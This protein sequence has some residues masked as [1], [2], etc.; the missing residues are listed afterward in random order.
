MQRSLKP[1]STGQ[2]R[3]DSPISWKLNRTSAPGLFRKQIVPLRGMGSMP[4]D[5]RHFDSGLAEQLMHSPCKRDQTGA[6]PVAG[7][8]SDGG[9]DVTASIRSCEDRRAGAAPVGLPIFQNARDAEIVEAAACKPALTRCESGRAL[10]F[11]G[12]R[13][14]ARRRNGIA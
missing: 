4:S 2:H 5:F 11:R 3:G 1:R 10:H 9:R 14:I 7:S 12:H 6:A 8:L 13:P